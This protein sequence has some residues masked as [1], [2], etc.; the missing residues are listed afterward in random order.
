MF[1]IPEE[2]I[3]FMTWKMLKFVKSAHIAAMHLNTEGYA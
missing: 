2:E 3:S 1:G